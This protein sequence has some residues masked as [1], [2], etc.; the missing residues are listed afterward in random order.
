MRTTGVEGCYARMH[1]EVKTAYPTRP[2][3][4]RIVASQ[5]MMTG[6]AG[7]LGL[8][9]KPRGLLG[10]IKQLRPDLEDSPASTPA[11]DHAWHQGVAVEDAETGIPGQSAA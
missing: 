3:D 8:H 9:A 1:A 4:Y 10:D 2:Y 11:S 7:A 5:A 6:P